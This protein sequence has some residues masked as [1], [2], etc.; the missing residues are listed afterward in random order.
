MGVNFK[1]IGESGECWLLNEDQ[2]AFPYWFNV[3]SHP[4]ESRSFAW[5][6]QCGDTGANDFLD[7]EYTSYVWNWR[8]REPSRLRSC[9]NRVAGQGD[10]MLQH[11][12]L[13]ILYKKRSLSI[14]RRVCCRI[15]A[16]FCARHLVVQSSSC[17]N[18]VQDKRDP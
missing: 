10:G 14:C 16:S 5:K 7:R 11:L 13:A 6:G 1:L 18:D 4:G 15:I 9:Q 3:T 2:V 8:C 12:V 17:Y